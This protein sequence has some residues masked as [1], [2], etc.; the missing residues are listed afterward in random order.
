MTSIEE[1]RE[2]LRRWNEEYLASGEP[3]PKSVRGSRWLGFDPA[4]EE[5][6]ET[7]ERRLGYRLPPSY[8]AFLLTTNGWRRPAA[9]VKRLR[10]AKK[11]E[12]LEVD[13]PQL[14]EAW[15]IGE[16][17]YGGGGGGKDRGEFDGLTAR[18]YFRYDA[19]TSGHY[20]RAHF[21]QSLKIADEIEGDS[22]IFLLN[23]RCVAEDGEWEAW[24]FANWIPGVV[25]H[26]SFAHLMRAQ[27]EAFRLY[28]DGAPETA[29]PKHIGPYTGVYAPDR[30]RHAAEKISPGQ[31]RKARPTIE[32]LV[33]DLENSSPK[34]RK[35]AAKALFREFKPRAMADV[36]PH[37][38]APLTRILTSRDAEADVRAAAAM[39][40]GSYGTADAV[41]PLADALPDPQ[42]A[43]SVASALQYLSIDVKDTRIADAFL[44]YLERPKPDRFVADQAL[45]VLQHSF[46]DTRLAPIALRMIDNAS[47]DLELRFA[48]AFALAD[49]DRARAADEL[50]ARLAHADSSTRHVAATAVRQTGDRRAIEPLR[51][52]LRDGDAAVRQQAET[53]LRI[54]GGDPH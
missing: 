13:D 30:P 17:M 44:K 10:A 1:W 14:L 29:K 4:S 6:I 32:Q 54:L 35:D 26:P 40:L 3:I 2:F 16:Q 28:Q 34:V 21:R 25:R 46:H 9:A 42:L 31:L 41:G 27:Y 7:L 36:R 37:L 23:P 33:A 52:L 53:S 51:A 22:Q 5:E 15:T 12:W 20:N 49:V 11:V 47:L 18:E 43:M 24:D 8:R 19:V 38:M 45:G 48:A 50:I 39:M